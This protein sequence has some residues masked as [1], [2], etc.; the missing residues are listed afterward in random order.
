MNEQSLATTTQGT[1]GITK[2]T[3]QRTSEQLK[4]MDELVQSIL[5]HGKD[6]GKIPG[7]QKPS[8][9]KPGA[10]TLLSTFNCYPWPTVV[11]HQVDNVSGFVSVIVR[12]E[13]IS[14]DTGAT[15]CAGL[16]SSTSHERKYRY[17]QDKN[18]NQVENPNPLDQHN[19]LVKMAEKRALV[20]CAMHLPGVARFFTQDVEEMTAQDLGSPTHTSGD[21]TMTCPEHNVEWFKR[22]RMPGFA[23]P[24]D[25]VTGPKGGTAWC[26]R[27]DALQMVVDQALDG[28]EPEAEASTGTEKDDE[29]TLIMGQEY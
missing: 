7:V 1:T 12:L 2:A 9:L 10:A 5:I 6:Y 19:T 21:M 8:L 15:R 11:D 13:A 17:R 24:I 16:G 25:G 22:G 14:F 3:I 29:M 18:G 28:T 23:H 27:E 4:L 20:D 26:N